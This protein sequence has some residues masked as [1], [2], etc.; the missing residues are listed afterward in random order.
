MPRQ[1]LS[2]QSSGIRAFVALLHAHAT[3][4]RQLNAQLT[5]DHGLTIN[6]YEVLLRLARAP[7][8]RMRRVDLADQVLLTASGITRLLDGLERDGFVVRASCDSD[9]RVVYAVL[10][11]AGVAKLNEATNTHFAQIDELFAERFDEDDLETVTGLLTRLA[12]PAA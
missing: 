5:A 7:E 9:R 8:R 6:D 11:D 10:T 2:E 12:E 3:A 1:V 4:T